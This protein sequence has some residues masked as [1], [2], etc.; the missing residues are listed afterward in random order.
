[1]GLAKEF[2]QKILFSDWVTKK[3]IEF[4]PLDNDREIPFCLS[5]TIISR[6]IEAGNRCFG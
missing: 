6:L 3:K 1:M 2:E 5:K 4:L